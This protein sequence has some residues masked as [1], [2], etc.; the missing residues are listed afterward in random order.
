MEQTTRLAS[1]RQQRRQH[2]NEQE[3]N[4]I[5]ARLK[6]EQDKE[7]REA[8]EILGAGEKESLKD[9]ATR[10]MWQAMPDVM[11]KRQGGTR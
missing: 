9:V 5:D 11:R 4:E 1:L 8:L 6:A 2:V 7:H 10:R 3:R